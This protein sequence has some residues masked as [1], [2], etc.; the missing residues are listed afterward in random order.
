[1]C[2]VLL[3]EEGAGR[4]FSTIEQP[5][6]PPPVS[7]CRPAWSQWRLDDVDSDGG[8]FGFSLWEFKSDTAAT[9]SFW[10]SENRTKL[11]EIDVSFA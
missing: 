6:P 3:L 7:P 11:T 8:T 4:V 9:L 1:M 5:A 10:N 2:G